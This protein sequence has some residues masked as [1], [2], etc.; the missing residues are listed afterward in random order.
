MPETSEV[1]ILPKLEGEALIVLEG[2]NPQPSKCIL[3]TS[4][5]IGIDSVTS[6]TAFSPESLQLDIVPSGT[7][8]K[9][10]AKVHMNSG[11]VTLYNTA[12]APPTDERS[13]INTWVAPFKFMRVIITSGSGK[14]TAFIS[15]SPGH[16][17]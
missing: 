6:L 1:N 12:T 17:G 3:D 10:Q 4:V 15:D 11:W 5:P 8:V 2:G 14:V 16:R 7:E 9:V 13:Y